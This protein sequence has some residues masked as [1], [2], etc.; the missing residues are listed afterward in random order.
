MLRYQGY[1]IVISFLVFGIFA[2]ILVIHITMI[3]YRIPQFLVS[4]LFLCGELAF[5][6]CLLSFVSQLSEFDAH[7]I[8]IMKTVIGVIEAEDPN[9][10]G[11]SLHVHNLAVM[12]YEY[13][14]FRYKIRV[15]LNKLE[16]AALLLDLGKFGV[17]REI[18]KKNGKLTKN[19]KSLLQRHPE[20]GAR[21]VKQID[22]FDEISEWIKYQ[23]ERIDG[24]GYYH[25]KGDEIPL[26]SRILAVADTFSAL[27]MQRS[28]RASLNYEQA[29]S[30]L[31][32][33]SGTQL[34]G[35]IVK[36]FCM[37]PLRKIEQSENSVRAKMSDLAIDAF[38]NE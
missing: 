8:E 32:I 33:V 2:A 35:E 15:N 20:F 38:I 18:I 36:Y 30:E 31:K 16:Y 24:N 22:F 14:P 11:H 34:D 7:G 19:E 5:T 29:I 37:I 10:E 26:E 3:F 1:R 17:P 25:L 6:L 13:L 23:H 21:I 4:T 12:L 27:T 9:L 28:Y